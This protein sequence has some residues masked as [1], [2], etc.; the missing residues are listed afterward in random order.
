MAAT[1]DPRAAWRRASVYFACCWAVALLSGAFAEL[2]GPVLLD[3]VGWVVWTV[4]ALAVVV[5]GYWVIWP[6]G[7]LTHGRPLRVGAVLAFGLAWGISEGLLFLSVWTVADRWLPWGVALAVTMLAVGTFLGLWHALYWDLKVAPE[8]NIES[9]NLRKVLL[10]HVPNLAVT[11]PYLATY[12]S[13]AVFVGCQAV[14][15]LGATWAMH[16]PPPHRAAALSQGTPGG[17]ADPG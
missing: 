3:D 2:P 1:Y 5:V 6:M 12:G 9:W 4:A 7:T 15:L 8:H 13:A 11:V 17:A 16:F 10:V 14:G